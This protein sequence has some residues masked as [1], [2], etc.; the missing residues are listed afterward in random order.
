MPDAT[1]NTGMKD[2]Q[3]RAQRGRG[4]GEPDRHEVAHEPDGAKDGHGAHGDDG[5]EYPAAHRQ[6]SCPRT[7]QPRVKLVPGEQEQEPQPDVG[8]QLYAGGV[9]QAQD[10]RADQDPGQDQDD[11][12]GNARPGQRGGDH[13]RQR[14]HQRHHQQ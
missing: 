8:E 5:A 9:G 10:M 1:K 13:R 2:G 12:L 4:Q 14:R 3:Q 6:P 7:Q 11:Y